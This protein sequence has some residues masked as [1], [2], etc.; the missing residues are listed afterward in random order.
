MA[1]KGGSISTRPRPLLRRHEGRQRHPAVEVDHARLF[2]A[3]QHGDQRFPRLR[4]ELAGD[5]SV[6]RPEQAAR[7]QRRARIGFELTL[8]IEGADDIEIGLYQRQGLVRQACLHQPRDAGQPFAAPARLVAVEIVEAGAGMGVD[9]AERPRLVLQ[10]GDDARQ[11]DVL[12]DIG[13][14]AGV[15]GVTIIHGGELRHRAMKVTAVILR[16]GA[17]HR[18]RNSFRHRLC[19]TMDSSRFAA[20]E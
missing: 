14:V 20:P 6:L 7:N 4:L 12:D 11:H 19:G 9:D 17:Q 1:S 5:E 15:E 16:G 2:V 8:R 10:I 18:A 3:A 13:E